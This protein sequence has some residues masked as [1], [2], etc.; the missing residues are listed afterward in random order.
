M[1][2]DL[3]PLPPIPSPPVPVAQV[4][5]E[6]DA[7]FAAPEP[8]CP[9]CGAPVHGPYCHACG[10]SEKGMVRSLKEVFSD[11]SDIVFNVDS[12]IFRSLFDLYFRPGFLTTEYIAGRRARYVTPF[13]LFFVLCLLAFFLVQ[14]MLGD[15]MFANADRAMAARAQ[16]DAA[17]TAAEVDT[18]IKQSIASLNEVAAATD[19]DADSRRQLEE[20]IKELAGV[21]RA[22]KLELARG[23][24]GTASTSAEVDQA[25]ADGLAALVD[26]VDIDA[27]PA[28]SKTRL[29]E[30][31]RQ[32]RESGERR[33]RVLAGT[34]A[35]SADPAEVVGSCGK[36]STTVFFT[37][38]G[39]PWHREA[40]PVA[41]D[42][43]PDAAN[44]KFNETLQHM[45]D[46]VE[47]W[48]EQPSKGFRATFAVLPQ[49]LFFLM[50]V[51]ALLLKLFYLFKRRLY[52]EHL[53]VALHSHAFLLL[54]IVVLV[55]LGTLK[56]WAA[57]VNW[58]VAPLGW[59]QLFAWLWMFV[60]LY[61][62]Q[63]RVYR[64]GWIMTTL[65]YGLIGICYTFLLSTGA[66][67][68]VLIGL[69]MD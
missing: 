56:S 17:T 34:E 46:N 15:A 11:L 4:R 2:S 62:M 18:A 61:W 35:P 65:K 52:M 48:I 41:F 55:I 38:K 21:G 8:T 59:L 10:Q 12:R 64:Q 47:S 24:I 14:A 39:T 66:F 68:A 29:D 6:A 22:R 44:M 36:G 58:I 19:L 30:R 50:P 31:Q 13:R 16:I 26:G 28:R 67:V 7:T 33:K 20:G 69:A 53:L 9:N 27:L 40:N 23:R 57:E 45:C 43:L 63:K 5:A 54:S 1:N 37:F 25:V 60:Y 49:T 42:W 51:F 32:L 3:D